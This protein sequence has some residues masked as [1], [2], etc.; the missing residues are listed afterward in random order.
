MVVLCSS[1][2]SRLALAGS[3]LWGLG[4]GSWLFRLLGLGLWFFHKRLIPWATHP[5][6]LSQH[7][8]P[9]LHPHVFSLPALAALHCSEALWR[10]T[11]SLVLTCQQSAHSK[12]N[13]PLPVGPRPLPHPNPTGCLCRLLEEHMLGW[14]LGVCCLSVS[15]YLTS[16]SAW[17]IWLLWYLSFLRCASTPL[18]C[19]HPAPLPPS[20]PSQLRDLVQ[21]GATDP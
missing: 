1:P 19:S 8:P 13:V 18:L 20:L 15:S 5:I 4:D 3:L 11:G 9:P 17:P 16:V 21:S 14:L 7:T 10:R 6:T 12:T 2:E